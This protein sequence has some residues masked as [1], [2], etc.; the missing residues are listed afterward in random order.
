M[1]L[2]SMTLIGMTL[3]CATHMC[4]AAFPA[5]TYS[6]T[7]TFANLRTD[8]DYADFRAGITGFEDKDFNRNSLARAR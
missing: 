6:K 8:N 3:L 5:A 7:L 1:K 4:I 2:K